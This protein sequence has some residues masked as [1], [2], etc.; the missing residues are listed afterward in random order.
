MRPLCNTKAK[1]CPLFCFNFTVFLNVHVVPL[2]VI[3]LQGTDEDVRFQS[4][5]FISLSSVVVRREEQRSLQDRRDAERFNDGFIE[6]SCLCTAS[7]N[8]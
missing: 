3:S 8:G 5:L 4:G 7:F 2:T 1:T 6:S